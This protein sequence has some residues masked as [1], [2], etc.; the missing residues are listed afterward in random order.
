MDRMTGV[1]SVRAVPGPYLLPLRILLPF[2]L[3]FCTIVGVAAVRGCPWFWAEAAGS[4]TMVWD[5][6]VLAK[7]AL[8][9][10]WRG[11]AA[12]L[13]ALAG[14]GRA[15]VAA[16][17]VL[18]VA[19]RGG[20]AVLTLARPAAGGTLP[21]VLTAAGLGFGLVSF[22]VF[23]LGLCGL[24]NTACMLAAAVPVV[25]AGCWLPPRRGR[26]VP[27]SLT[28]PAGARPGHPPR[29]GRD[30]RR[31]ARLSRGPADAQHPGCRAGHT[32]CR[33]LH[34]GDPGVPAQTPA[35]Q[36]RRL[37]LKRALPAAGTTQR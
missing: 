37:P 35:R 23:G 15:V 29:A 34:G 17:A 10:D 18:A 9:R 8:A 28:R 21:A 36:G 19:W 22:G 24:L 12:F 32:R 16:V 11:T 6:P 20:A 33:D 27:R 13:G 3:L 1:S 5:A 30:G 25:A 4:G 14:H 7:L 26:R 31:L 2:S